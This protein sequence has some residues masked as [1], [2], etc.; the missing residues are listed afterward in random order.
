MEEFHDFALFDA[1]SAREYE[2]NLFA[3]EFLLPDADVLELMEEGADFYAMASTLA[4]PPELLD[5]KLRVLAGKG[6]LFNEPP[7]RAR[8]GFLKDVEVG[9]DEE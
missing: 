1:V 4:V 3:A 9:F 7:L 5:F 8:G 6:L 2:A